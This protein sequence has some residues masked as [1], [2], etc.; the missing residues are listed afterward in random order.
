MLRGY[1]LLTHLVSWLSKIAPKLTWI[2]ICYVIIMVLT[3]WNRG[4]EKA[5]LDITH[6]YQVAG[7]GVR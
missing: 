1:N 5:D 7:L 6:T 2:M 3:S 4:S